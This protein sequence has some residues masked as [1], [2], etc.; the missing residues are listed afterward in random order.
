MPILRVSISCLCRDIH[1]DTWNLSIAQKDEIISLV[2]RLGLSYVE[3]YTNSRLQVFYTDKS[4]VQI[5]T[6]LSKLS[7][8]YTVTI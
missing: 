2:N 3:N 5:V 4:A 8:E 6:L 1:V 7:Q